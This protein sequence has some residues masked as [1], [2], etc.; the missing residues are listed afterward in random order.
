MYYDWDAIRRCKERMEAKL[1]KQKHSM[2]IREQ[3]VSGCLELLHHLSNRLRS[4]W[5]NIQ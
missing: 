1:E 4:F 2:T 5:K 3:L